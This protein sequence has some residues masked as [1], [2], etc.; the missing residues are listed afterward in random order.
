MC[1]ILLS[2]LVTEINTLI[3]NA[4][5]LRAQNLRDALDQIIDDPVMRA[6]IYTHPLIQLVEERAVLPT[7]RISEEDAARVAEGVQSAT[8][9]WIDSQTFVDVVLNNIKVESDQQLFGAMLNVIDGMPSGPGTSG[10]T[11]DG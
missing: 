6:K 3:S 10:V 2:I 8:I 4:L 5:R 7:Q 11:F 9:D 1:I